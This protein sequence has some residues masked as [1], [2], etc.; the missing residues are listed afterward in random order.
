MD[1]NF[2][3]RRELPNKN[4]YGNLMY[5]EENYPTL[6]GGLKISKRSYLFLGVEISCSEQNH[7]VAIFNEQ[8]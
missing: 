4:Y 7:I 6:Q 1:K 3:W 2:F 8:K 5:G